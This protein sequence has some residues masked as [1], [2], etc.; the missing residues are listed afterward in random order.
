[1]LVY[2]DTEA[3]TVDSRASLS[4][5]SVDN[6]TYFMSSRRPWM[7]R[8]SLANNAEPDRVRGLGKL[9]GSADPRNSLTHDGYVAP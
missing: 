2:L 8:M 5:K 7:V 1:M 4:V 6:T 3:N 9:T